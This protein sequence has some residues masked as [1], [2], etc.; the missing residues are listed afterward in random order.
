MDFTFTEYKQILQEL[1]KDFTF[2]SFENFSAETKIYLRHDLDIMIENVPIIAKIESELGIHS[3]FFF[4]PN[5][6]FYNPLSKNSTTILNTVLDNGHS[7]GLH[8]D[9]SLIQSEEQLAVLIDSTYR[10]Y[11]LFFPITKIISFH[12]PSA[13]IL[14]GDI[15][16]PGFINT[17][18]NSFFKKIRYFSDSNRRAFKE[19]L[20]QSIEADRK[21][22]IQLLIHPYWW[23]H[24]SLTILGL[25]NRL[26]KVKSIQIFKN[27]QQDFKPYQ[28][29]FH[30]RF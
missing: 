13:S 14:E 25:Y 12:I 23:D 2:E 26:Q 3:I 16:I 19:P 6:P 8:I 17:Y 4:Q 15:H 7:L 5:N 28:T 20:L 24:I 1:K 21:K 11:S 30:E 29:L 27:L 9:A 10:Y 22:S 18:E